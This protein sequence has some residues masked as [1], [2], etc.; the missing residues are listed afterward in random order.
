[1]NHEDAIQQ[2]R[3]SDKTAEDYYC[4]VRDCSLRQF[5]QRLCQKKQFCQFL[6]M[7]E[8]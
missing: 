7:P 2:E 4:I 8:G 3:K 1:M 5:H 6:I